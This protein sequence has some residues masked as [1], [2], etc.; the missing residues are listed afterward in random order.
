[1]NYIKWNPIDS[2]PD[3][4]YL[5]GLHDDYEGFRVLLRG[6][7]IHSR[8][9]RIAFDL[10]LFYRN[11]D[12]GSFLKTLHAITEQERWALY[13]VENSSLISWFQEESYGVIYR[14]RQIVHYA[15]LTPNDCIDILSEHEPHV[16]WLN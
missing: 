8:M 7:D 1:M 2:L 13:T 6:V 5:E 16:G 9:L 3:C 14:N 4:L 11:I 15:I 10:P 12:E